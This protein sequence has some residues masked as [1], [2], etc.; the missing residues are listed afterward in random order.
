MLDIF[1]KPESALSILLPSLEKM[2]KLLEGFLDRQEKLESKVM[3]LRRINDITIGAIENNVGFAIQRN[4]A[5]VIL[6]VDFRS[7]EL[8]NREKMVKCLTILKDGETQVDYTREKNLKSRE[9][10]YYKKH[11]FV[12]IDES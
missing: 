4:N 9:K 12:L 3:E 6:E 1:G 11:K 7:G 5:E 8:Y 10:E 2:C